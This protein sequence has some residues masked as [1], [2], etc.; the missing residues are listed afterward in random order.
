MKFRLLISLFLFT[1][2]AVSAQDVEG[3]WY[4][5]IRNKLINVNISK[6]SVIIRKCDF[7][8]NSYE[9]REVSARIVKK[10]ENIYIVSADRDGEE[11]FWLFGFR[12]IAGNNMMNAASFDKKYVSL[13]EAEKDINVFREV[14]VEIT[15]LDKAAISKIKKKRDINT[16]TADDFKKFAT[17]IIAIDTANAAFYAKKYKLAYLY[18]ESIARIALSEIGINCLIKGNSF[19]SVMSKFG[20]DP[21][22]KDLFDELAQPK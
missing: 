21:E 11:M 15:L 5:P 9:F 10:A 18:G 14:N 2:T 22:T 16:M 6:D 7:D 1:I 19:T 13:E 17:K 3:D 12:R 8:L 4:T 20:Q